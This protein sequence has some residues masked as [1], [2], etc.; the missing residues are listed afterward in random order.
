MKHSRLDWIIVTLL[1]LVALWS[2]W[3]LYMPE[4][5]VRDDGPVFAR[6]ESLTNVVKS[7]PVGQLGWHDAQLGQGFKARDQLFTYEQS[8]ASLSF[9]NGQ[10]LQLWPNTLIELDGSTQ[11]LNLNLKQGV[12]YLDLKKNDRVKILV[13]EEVMTV[14]GNQALVKL[15]RQ[16]HKTSIETSR[17]QLQLLTQAGEKL[18]LDQSSVLEIDENNNNRIKQFDVTLVNPTDGQEVWTSL[19]QHKINFKW[20]AKDARPYKLQLSNDLNFV[21][22]IDYSKINEAID[23]SPGRYFWRALTPQGQVA[24]KVSSFDLKYWSAPW[25]SSQSDQDKNLKIQEEQKVNIDLSW[26]HSEAKNFEL[27][28]VVDEMRT[29][30]TTDQHELNYELDKVGQWRFRVRALGPV[31]S[32]WSEPISFNV[33]NI[34]KVELLSPADQA[35]ILTEKPGDEVE[36]QFSGRGRIEISRLA[37]FSKILISEE[38]TGSY[39]FKVNALG[40]YYW[41]LI[42]EGISSDTFEFNIAPGR[43]LPAPEL[44]RAPSEQHLE[45]LKP[46][47]SLWLGLILGQAFAQDFAAV[48]DWPEV[49]GASAYEIE[50]FADAQGQRLLKSVKVTDHSFTWKNASLRTVWWRVRAIDAWEQKGEFSSLNSMKFLAPREWGSDSVDLVE[51]A[52]GINIE[53]TQKVIFEWDEKSGVKEWEWLLS[54]D[55]SFSN[56][57]VL[58]K[59]EKTSFSVAKIPAG[60]WY[61]KVR[62]TDSLGRMVE[63]RRRRLQVIKPTKQEIAARQERADEVERRFKLRSPF[64]IEAGLFLSR[65]SYALENEGKS[66]DLSGFSASGI[67]FSLARQVKQWNYFLNG[68][69]ISGSA[70]DGLAYRDA[71]ANLGAKKG[72]DFGLKYPV[73]LGLSVSYAQLSS[74]SRATNSNELNEETLSQIGIA[75]HLS[76]EPWI[77]AEDQFVQLSMQLSAPTRVALEFN[78]R[79]Y[80]GN[81]FWGASIQKTEFNKD[82]SDLGVTT[83]G[84]Q[85][86]YRWQREGN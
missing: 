26:Q 36:L 75:A 56:P 37:D 53:T 54:S 23:I 78:A 59:I 50:I 41:R 62:G 46:S 66:F 14:Q 47:S 12:V 3:H 4:T 57:K 17:G 15:S 71:N 9:E 28:V 2:G 83:F 77:I 30:I 31:V 49:E 13:N 68:Y 45:L 72:F 70:F 10:N 51:P 60:T 42:R 82:E 63:S 19:R 64:D 58:K 11:D 29:S 25:F 80:I 61:W 35:M 8:R 67:V 40:R 85:L 84:L 79:H 43:P 69:F 48:F 7:K 27:E 24:S 74:Y 32:E 34:K 44:E 65:P 5:S 20:D 6:L 73:W 81:W 55:L 76:I 18:K 22:S 1:S 86:G 16:G 52:H 21:T 39:Q 33:Q 38:V